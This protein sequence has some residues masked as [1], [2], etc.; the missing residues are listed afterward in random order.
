MKKEYL[1]YYLSRMVLSAV[2]AVIVFGL[3]WQA[4]IFALFVFA[5]FLLYLHSGW[6]RIDLTHPLFPLR[7]DQRAQLIQRKALIVALLVGVIVY[8]V[9]LFVANAMGLP[10][11]TVNLAVPLAI[12]VYFL[13]QFVLL[14]QA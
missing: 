4:L 5:L 3:S 6:F 12:V 11:L 8:M 9:Q 2:F 13:A 1:P 7:R 14:R 10:F